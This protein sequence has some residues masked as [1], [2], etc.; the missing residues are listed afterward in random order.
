MATSFMCVF[1]LLGS[2]EVYLHS[3]HLLGF[4][5]LLCCMQLSRMTS[6]GAR[7]EAAGACRPQSLPLLLA[8]A[9]CCPD[10]LALGHHPF[11]TPMPLLLPSL[12]AY[13][14]SVYSSCAPVY[15]ISHNCAHLTLEK[16]ALCVVG[17]FSVAPQLLL[18][19]IYFPPTLPG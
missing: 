19:L 15:S 5:P 4:C 18:V 7:Q 9:F 13:F 3:L 11:Q 6:L 14:S 17:C 16:H 12:L 8:S 10:I 1:R 2:N